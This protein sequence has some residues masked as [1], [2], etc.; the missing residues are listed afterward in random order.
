MFLAKCGEDEGGVRNR[1]K[2][3][4]RL[5]SLGRAAAKD[6]PVAHGDQRLANLIARAARVV[7]GIHEAGQTRLLV[8]IQHPPATPPPP[9]SGP[10][11]IIIPPFF[12]STPPRKSPT[13]K[14]GE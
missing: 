1:Q 6:A 3:T 13:S 12:H 9:A 8:G 7:I 5:R 2:V 10:P 4:L 14:I 11:K